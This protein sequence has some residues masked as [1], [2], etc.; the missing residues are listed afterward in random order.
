MW[1]TISKARTSFWIQICESVQ[2]QNETSILERSLLQTDR[3]TDSSILKLSLSLLFTHKLTHTRMNTTTRKSINVEWPSRQNLR[4]DYFSNA[5]PWSTYS[6]AF[7][8]LTPAALSWDPLAVIISLY[9]F[10]QKSDTGDN[11]GSLSRRPLALRRMRTNVRRKTMRRKS[12]PEEL[13]AK[14]NVPTGTL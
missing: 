12:P 8:I 13:P 4:S 11:S 5:P 10:E 14:T 2:H 1:I 6:T 7:V 3:H 9:C